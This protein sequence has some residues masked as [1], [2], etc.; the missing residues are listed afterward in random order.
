MTNCSICNIK[1]TRNYPLYSDSDACVECT[2]K[3]KSC[4][5]QIIPIDNDI[6]AKEF[7][8]ASTL[9][10]NVLRGNGDFIVLD[11]CGNKTGSDIMNDDPILNSMDNYKD[12]LL[13]SLYSQVEFLRSEIEEKNLLIRSLIIK[14]N[15]VYDGIDNRDNS[16]HSTCSS[17][18]TDSSYSGGDQFLNNGDLNSTLETSSTN[19]EGEGENDELFLDLNQQ[20]QLEQEKRYIATEIKI[21]NQLENIRYEKH[22]EYISMCNTGNYET[23]EYFVIDRGIENLL[24]PLNSCPA[25][26]SKEMEQF[27]ID[28][29]DDNKH[30]R[31]WPKNT[32]LIATDSMFNQIDENRLSK[33][34]NVKVRAFSGATIENMYWY[35]QPLL[36]KEPDYLLLHVGSNNCLT[37]TAD[38]ILSDLLKLK[39]HIENTLPNCSVILSQPII[40]CDNQKAAKIINEFIS[41]FNYLDVLTLDN[42]NIVREQLG[43]KGLHLNDQGTRQLAMNIIS[44][45]RGL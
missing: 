37:H 42:S 26:K 19:E 6:V 41:K 12:A 35:L 30:V 13:A 25:P 24:S 31:K 18:D 2:I 4:D 17:S 34:Y 21:K 36:A 5:L 14:E 7:K 32:I 10:R 20:S 3:L 45:I 16:I 40:R 22:N 1:I 28:L 39:Q 29:H 8:D 23:S 43:K 9:P 33:K 15:E 11:S 38:E 44:L 27:F